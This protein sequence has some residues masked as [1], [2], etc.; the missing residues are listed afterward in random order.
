VTPFLKFSTILYLWNNKWCY[1]KF[2][3][4][5]LKSASFAT[6]NTEHRV[7]CQRS[8][9]SL[10]VLLWVNDLKPAPTLVCTRVAASARL[11]WLEEL[12]EHSNAPLGAC[13]WWWWW[14]WNGT[15]MTAITFCI[16]WMCFLMRLLSV[17]RLLAHVDVSARY[18]AWICNSLY[19]RPITETSNN[20]S[21]SDWMRQF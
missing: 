20:N 10:V 18:I 7:V 17:W 13:Y 6:K 16:D 3:S 1:F 15:A 19:S 14:W 4:K 9:L 5:T 21:M 12:R 8:Q 11:C 2:Y